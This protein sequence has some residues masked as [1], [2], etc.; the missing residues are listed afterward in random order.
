M[1][2]SLGNSLQPVNYKDKTVCFYGHGAD[3]AVAEA[4]VGVFGRVLYFM[5]WKDGFPASVKAKIGSGIKGI[6]RIEHFFDYIDEIDLFVFLDIY[7]GDLQA[8]LE[9]LGKKVFGSRKSEDLENMRYET[10]VMMRDR[11][12]LPVQPIRRIIGFDKLCN[13]LKGTKDQYIKIH[14]LS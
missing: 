14:I 8:H 9:S 3:L 1:K 7:D 4:M 13:Y 12:G 11:L 5:P 2:D 6:E 10:K